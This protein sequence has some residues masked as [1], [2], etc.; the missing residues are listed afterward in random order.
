L[1]LLALGFLGAS[2]VEDAERLVRQ[3]NAAYAH[4]DH[5]AAVELFAQA[6]EYT[7]DPGLV[8]FNKA[9]ALYRL[10]RYADAEAHYLQSREDAS[11]ARLA[12][13][14]FDLGNSVLQ[15]ARDQD[16][17][18]IKRAIGYYEECL[19]QEAA[20][21]ELVEDAK[22]NLQLAKQLL[23]RA[24]A[25]KGSREPDESPDGSDRARDEQ[26]NQGMNGMD[27]QPGVPDR[28]GQARAVNRRPGDAQRLPGSSSQEPPPGQGDLPPIQD[29]EALGQ[30]SPE[31]TARYLEKVAA[32]VLR[33]RREQRRQ[34]RPPSPPNVMNW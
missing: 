6:E 10:G 24:R 18:G 1:A 4:G 31:E 16:I 12:R 11:G 5:Q 23:A 13:V 34:S 29:Q 8:A 32:Q 15:V 22:F 28:R 20:G 33:E 2:P 19:R 30:M 9:A 3:G 7:T 17:K 27:L 25:A 14:L 21:P 26:A